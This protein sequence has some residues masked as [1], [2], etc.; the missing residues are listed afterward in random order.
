MHSFRNQSNIFY[1]HPSQARPISNLRT[2]F[3]QHR[4][5]VSSEFGVRRFI[6]MPY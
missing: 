1:L 4:A 3:A 2:A 5:P 6:L